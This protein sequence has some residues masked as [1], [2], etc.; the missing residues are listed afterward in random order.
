MSHFCCCLLVVGAIVLCPGGLG[1]AEEAINSAGFK[2]AQASAPVV[3]TGKT[4]PN[5]KPEQPGRGSRKQPTAEELQATEA[6]YQHLQEDQLKVRKDTLGSR[7]VWTDTVI[8]E[9]TDSLPP[10]PLGKF[11]ELLHSDEGT[12]SNWVHS[13]FETQLQAWHPAKR[14]LHPDK[15]GTDEITDD[16]GKTRCFVNPL[17]LSYILARHPQAS[18]LIK[19]AADPVLFTEGGRICAILAPWTKLPDGTS[20]L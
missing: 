9:I 16:A 3:D 19:T 8:V 5:G 1:F 4:E 11:L 13:T 14:S 2:I 7:L 17:Y 12:L 15:P 20:L 18:V 10:E 6:L